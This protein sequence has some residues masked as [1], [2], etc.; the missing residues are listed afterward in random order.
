MSSQTFQAM[1]LREEDKK[2]IAAIETLSFDALPPEDTLVKIDYSTIN[3]KDAL[4]VTGKSK[5]VRTL[6]LVPGIDFSDT[7]VETTHS[8]LKVGQ[9]V[10]LT[11]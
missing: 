1:I 10:V 8:G 7:V 2:T 4:A 9:H 3:F 5:I 6:P 11:G